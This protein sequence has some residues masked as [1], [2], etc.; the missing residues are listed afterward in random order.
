MKIDHVIS[1]SETA[2]VLMR[3]RPIRKTIPGVD[4][5]DIRL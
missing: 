2:T 3:F 4:S 1:G 5:F